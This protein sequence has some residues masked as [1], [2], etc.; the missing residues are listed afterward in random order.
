MA[1]IAVYQTPGHNYTSLLYNKECHTSEDYV[2]HY[3]VGQFTV[4]SDSCLQLPKIDICLGPTGYV[5]C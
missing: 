5:F 3:K 1:A 2:A 4:I